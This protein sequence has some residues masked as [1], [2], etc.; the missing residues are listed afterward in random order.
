MTTGNLTDANGIT[1]TADM[2][3][4]VPIRH[5]E[6]R[7]MVH[8]SRFGST[9]WDIARCGKSWS[10]NNGPVEWPELFPTKKEAFAACEAWHESVNR[11]WAQQS[12]TA[13]RALI[14]T[15]VGVVAHEER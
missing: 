10:I 8:L 12:R 3:G 7:F 4:L 2:N 9:G 1:Y 15:G 6:A 11:R 13:S 5:D 14:L